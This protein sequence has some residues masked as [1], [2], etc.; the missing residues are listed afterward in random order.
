[1]TSEIL[2]KSLRFIEGH[3]RLYIDLSK[4]KP[5][6]RFMNAEGS[7]YIA[8]LL[9]G[10]YLHEAPIITSRICGFCYSAHTTAS[11]LAI[12]NALNI[13]IS[14]EVELVRKIQLY[15]DHIK[16]HILHLVYLVY[17]T[18][19]GYFN[20]LRLWGSEIVKI[21]LKV[22]KATTKVIEAV[23]GRVIHTPIMYPGGFT[24]KVY[25]DQIY[26]TV[27]KYIHPLLRDIIKLAEKFIELEVPEFERQRPI[28]SLH[29]EDKYD[30]YVTNPMIALN[31]ETFSPLDFYKK[32][33]FIPEIYSTSQHVLIN[34]REVFTGAL[35]RMLKYWRRLNP[36]AM[37]LAED[38]EWSSNPFLN[39]KAQAIEVV[40]FIE[41]MLKLAKEIKN[42]KLDPVE[43]YEKLKEGQGIGVI[44]APRGLLIH[45]LEVLDN[46]ITKYV[47]LPPTVFNSKSIERDTED[48]SY[49]LRE[50]GKEKLKPIIEDLVRA[51]DPCTSCAVSLD[52][53]VS[54]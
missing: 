36:Y 35:V 4:R 21:G 42:I 40:N 16:S 49:K 2:L 52:H 41:E 10:R 43:K 22:A 46:K 14:E 53:T 15:A 34:G 17:P 1:M 30:L 39:I 9:K 45:Y 24:F 5:R 6:A 19:L 12:E 7:R 23:G 27:Y 47:I 31:V 3:A 44:E 8:Q 33:E 25:G 20:I 48:L 37:S 26:E 50:L 38:I 18:Y 29:M 11:I 13:E 54:Q 28:L 51:Y 32:I